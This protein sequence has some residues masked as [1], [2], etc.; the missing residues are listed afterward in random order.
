MKAEREALD[1]RGR[2]AHSKQDKLMDSLGQVEQQSPK[3][4][5]YISTMKSSW[6]H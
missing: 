6:N 2:S 5:L 1:S 4:V 3:I